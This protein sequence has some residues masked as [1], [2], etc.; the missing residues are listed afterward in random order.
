MKLKYIMLIES[1]L[2][3]YRTIHTNKLTSRVLDGSYVSV[4]KG[5]SMNFSE[6]REYVAGDDIR[7]ID[8]KA[9]ARN[10]SKKLLVKQYIA[11]K[12]HNIMLCMDTNKRMLADTG[13]GEE[14]REVALVSAGA[15]AYLVSKNGDYVSATYGT[16]NSI[17]HYPFKSGN[18]NIET[19]LEGYY[20]EVTMDNESTIIKDI[21]Y[22]LQNFRKKM[23]ILIVT[24]I[25][26]IRQMDERLLKQLKANNDVLMIVIEDANAV[27]ENVYSV[28][29]ER[30]LPDFIT[31]DKKLEKLQ[32]KKKKQIYKECDMKLKK[33]KIPYSLI[34][35]S[36]EIDTKII[37]LLNKNKNEKRSFI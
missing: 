20:K 6:L 25:E 2:K 37:E 11:D 27:G 10:T 14:K 7:D 30:Y 9:S 26:G 18:I 28:A 13:D 8:F 5:R 32:I 12:K 23:I 21:E 15:L 34:N 16:Q 3:K 1:K 4:H 29:N 33:C 24:D 22:I 19:I 36:N 35:N 17:K 31:S